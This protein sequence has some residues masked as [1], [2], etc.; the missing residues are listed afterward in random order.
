M[1]TKRLIL[2]IVSLALVFAFAGCANR[3]D[4]VPPGF[5]AAM[6]VKPEPYT[7]TGWVREVIHE[8]TGI[9]MVFIPAGE[10]MMGSNDGDSNEMPVHKV[11]ITRPFYMGKYEVTIKEYMS[12]LNSAGNSSGADLKDE[13]CPVKRVGNGYS[14]SRNKFGQDLRQPMAE[15]SWNGSKAFCD[16]AGLRLPTEAEWEYACRAGTTTAYTFGG[17]DDNLSRYAW[18]W[19][20]NGHKTCPVGGKI[21]NAW[22][23]YDM[24]G[25]VWEWCADWYDKS[26][27]GM[28][29]TEDPKGPTSGRSRIRRGGSW[30]NLSNGCRSANR[31]ANSPA[32]ASGDIGFRVVRGL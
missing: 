1:L 17:D 25:N 27:Y 21:L 8:K 19:D 28:S 24:H 2:S 18:H 10:F 9:E 11:R 16:W 13:D 6:D 32:D 15:V 7:N 14:L 5:R 23:L 3:A 12:F 26:Y 4:R 31:G 22:H 30:F 20:N 29:P